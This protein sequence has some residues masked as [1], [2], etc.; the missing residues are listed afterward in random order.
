[1]IYHLYIQKWNAI[2]ES[3][4]NNP[5]YDVNELMI[6]SVDEQGSEFSVMFDLHGTT[7]ETEVRFFDEHDKVNIYVNIESVYFLDGG[8]VYLDRE[9]FEDIIPNMRKLFVDEYIFN[10][11]VV[12]QLNKEAKLAILLYH[13]IRFLCDVSNYLS[14][15]MAFKIDGGEKVDLEEANQH[16]R[17]LNK[18]VREYVN[19]NKINRLPNMQV[20]IIKMYE[21]AVDNTQYFV[22]LRRN[23]VVCTSVLGSTN[24]LEY[25]CYQTKHHTKDECLER[26]WMMASYLVRFS[27]ETSMDCVK[28]VN[29]TDEEIQKIKSDDNITTALGV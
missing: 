25:A 11:V 15:Q 27:G 13:D 20:Q 12:L 26:A 24:V 9:Y 14:I 28:L 21:S 19:E 17:T 4:L 2:M 22:R 6:A 10:N 23:D 5:E 1:M 16:V 18:E 29:F 8:Y 3:I 7:I